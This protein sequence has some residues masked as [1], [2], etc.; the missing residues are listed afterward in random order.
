[1]HSTTFKHF[2]FDFDDYLSQAKV[3]Q[4]MGSMGGIAK[5]MP[6]MGNIQCRAWE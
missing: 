5:M 1:M 3:M 2:D 4:S 6:G